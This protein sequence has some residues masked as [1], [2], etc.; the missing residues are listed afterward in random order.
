M[1]FRDCDFPTGL[2]SKIF[3]CFYCQKFIFESRYGSGADKLIF[4][5]FWFFGFDFLAKQGGFYN[6]VVF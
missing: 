5:L 3:T 6:S 2:R 4:L 1:K